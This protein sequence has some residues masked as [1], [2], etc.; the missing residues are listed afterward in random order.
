MNILFI[1]DSLEKIKPLSDT[2]L[3]IV[4]QWRKRKHKVYWAM[5]QG[6]EFAGEKVTVQAS[7]IKECVPEA[8]PVLAHPQVFNIDQFKCVFI[9]KDPPFDATYV[10]LCWLLSLAENRTV[11]LNAPSQL[12]RYHEK[13]VPLE[14]F[15]QG[16]LSKKDLIPTF[17][18][19]AINAKH[20]VN[21][22]KIEKVIVKPFL[23]FGGSGVE[24]KSREDFVAASAMRD[25]DIIVQ[26]FQEEVMEGDHRVFFLEGKLIG[27]FARIPKEGGFISNLAAGGSAKP[28]PLTKPQKNLMEKVGKFLK[29]QK[30][31]FAGADLIGNHV[32]EV[33]ITSPTG[34]VVYEKLFGIDLSE[35][36]VTAALK[37]V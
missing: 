23:G 8:K 32:S 25:E 19:S 1:A 14:A 24:L 21:Q 35:T 36:L 12:L 18:G 10:R 5:D 3:V 2:T 28:V 30:I 17:L 31:F 15:A 27:S 26:P 6:V 7:E 22:Y 37:R 13:L 20:F 4:R 9:R 11:F 33:N 29:K 16:F 34:F